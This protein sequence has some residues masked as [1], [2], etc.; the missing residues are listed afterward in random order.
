MSSSG[1]QP[2]AFA[3]E[4]RLMLGVLALVAPLP[5]PWNDVLE[6]PV[7]LLF[8]VAVL[9]FLRRAWRGAETWLPSW[10]LNVLGLAY[11]PVLYLDLLVFWGGQLVRPVIHLGLFAVGVKL[12]GLRQERDKWHVVIGAFFLFLAAMGTSVHPAI[13]LYL[14]AFL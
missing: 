8:G 13:L 2:L 12:F 5:L 14:A 11:L 6:I 1:T 7:A 10:A 4:K 9:V 3:R